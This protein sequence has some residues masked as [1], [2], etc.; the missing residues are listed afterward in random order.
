MHSLAQVAKDMPGYWQSRM[1]RE[2]FAATFLPPNLIWLQDVDHLER[3]DHLPAN[4]DLGNLISLRLRFETVSEYGFNSRIGR[5]LE[6]SGVSVIRP[7]PERLGQAV[8]QLDQMLPNEMEELRTAFTNGQRPGRTHGQGERQREALPLR[9][10]TRTGTFFPGS[11]GA[12]LA[13][14]DRQAPPW[15]F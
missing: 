7:D 8:E 10:S 13:F 4:S 1:D 2:S 3:H 12:V 15:L 11:P 5:T 9:L 6:K 14:W